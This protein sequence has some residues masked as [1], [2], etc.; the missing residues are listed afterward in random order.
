MKDLLKKK[1]GFSLVELMLVIAIIAIISVLAVGG[2]SNYRRAALVNL[3]ADNL[4]AQIYELKEKTIHGNFG[5]ERFE[6][7]NAAIEG[8]DVLNPEEGVIDSQCSGLYF[9]EDGLYKV[10]Q[11]F[12]GLQKWNAISGAFEYVACESFNE[13]DSSFFIEKSLVE[14]EA[15]IAGV[16]GVSDIGNEAPVSDFFIKFVPPHGDVEVDGIGLVSATESVK[17]VIKYGESDDERFM[18]EV[19]INLKSGDAEVVQE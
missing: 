2:Y 13:A 5:R 14:M 11:R 15:T 19:S 16:T 8:G 3:A 6:V 4:V 7:I 18:R 17:I 9:G 12:D 1:E 10:K